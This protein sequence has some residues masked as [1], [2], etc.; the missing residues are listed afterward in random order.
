MNP[1]PVGF[2]GMSAPGFVEQPVTGFANSSLRVAQR[3]TRLGD[4]C[5]VI[6]GSVLSRHTGT[7]ATGGALSNILDE[8]RCKSGHL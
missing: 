2:E 1:A 7:A 4:D 3:G 5:P 6:I 8:T